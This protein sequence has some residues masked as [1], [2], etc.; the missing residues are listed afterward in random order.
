MCKPLWQKQRLVDAI[1]KRWRTVIYFSGRE[2][3][4]TLRAR[5]YIF[6][7]IFQSESEHTPKIFFKMNSY[8]FGTWRS[9]IWMITPCKSKVVYSWK[10][11]YQYLTVIWIWSLIG[12]GGTFFAFLVREKINFCTDFSSRSLHTSVPK[13]GVGGGGRVGTLK[14][15]FLHWPGGRLHSWSS[16]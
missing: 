4:P 11:N 12:F 13:G 2:S 8:L 6:I 9:L 1:T 10:A 3:R 5:K 15:G 16:K 7:I 14:M